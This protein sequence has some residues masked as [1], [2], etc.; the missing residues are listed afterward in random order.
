MQSET[1]TT[2]MARLFMI[3]SYVLPVILMAAGLIILQL[4]GNNYHDV[5]NPY[6]INVS[7]IIFLSAVPT[8]MLCVCV[9]DYYDDKD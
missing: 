7:L 3:L 2:I 8:F 5:Y 4:L 9:F 1:T 6:W